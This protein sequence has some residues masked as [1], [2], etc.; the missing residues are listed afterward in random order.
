MLSIENHGLTRAYCV[1]IKPRNPIWN[2]IN[3]DPHLLHLENKK[4]SEH[5]CCAQTYIFTLA[6]RQMRQTRPKP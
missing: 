6:I 1:K 4:L 2:K 5:N 3:F